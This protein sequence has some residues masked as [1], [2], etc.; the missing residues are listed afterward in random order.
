MTLLGI[1]VGGNPLAQPVPLHIGT[2]LSDQEMW[3]SILRTL[4]EIAPWLARTNAVSV[5]R[6]NDLIGCSPEQW[7]GWLEGN[8]HL[9]I[10]GRLGRLLFADLMSNIS[11]THCLRMASSTTRKVSC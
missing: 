4:S 1:E 2:V 11:R 8:E 5:H 3:E 7:N 6:C 10:G 9:P